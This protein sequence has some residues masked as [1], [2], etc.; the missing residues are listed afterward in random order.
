MK[1][2][3][4]PKHY[5]ALSEIPLT[6]NGKVDKSLLPL[7]TLNKKT[8][9]VA[10]KTKLQKLIHDIMCQLLNIK[11]LSITT[12]FFDFSIDSLTIIKAQANLYGKGYIVNTQAFYEYSNIQDLEKFILSKNENKKQNIIDESKDT[13]LL[14]IKDIQHPINSHIAN[15][16]NILLLGATGFLGIH[17]LYELLVNTNSYI[18][19]IIRE[20]NNLSSKQRIIESLDFYFKDL[21]I[22]NYSDRLNIITGDLLK[23]NFG[24]SNYNFNNLGKNIDCVIDSA[25]I[26]KHYGDY[27]LFY[28]LN[29]I[30]TKRVVEFCI[31]YNIP[32]HYIST[33]SVSG[34]GLV[35]SP[36]SIFSETDFYIGQNYMDNVYVRSKFEAEKLILDSCKE[37]KLIANIYRVGNIT[38]RFSDGCFQ[39]NFYDNAFIN[40]LTAFINLRMCT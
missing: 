21:Q 34:Y 13:T 12:D 16:K 11:N 18:Y 30:G 6:V 38:N 3:M 1:A 17:M 7:P 10:P 36:N 8:K 40:R 9:F 2:N 26:V 39:K 37:K 29:V 27:K 23:N 24:L 20:K 19:C 32:L 14:S 25:A 4:I 5:I 31:Q 35:N 15:H 22:E 28:D 33:L